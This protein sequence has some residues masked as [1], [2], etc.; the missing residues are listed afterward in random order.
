MIAHD[1][2]PATTVDGTARF[3]IV[4][5]HGMMEHGGRYHDFARHLA[6]HG[7]NVITFDLRGHGQHLKAGQLGDFGDPIDGGAAQIFTDME[8]LFASF[9]NNLPNILFGHSMG[10]TVALRY[11][12]THSGLR[13]IILSAIPTNPPWLLSTGYRLAKLEARL[14]PTKPSVFMTT[15]KQ[16]N[17][18]FKPN[19]TEFDWL[20]LD[21]GNIAHYIDDPMCG[22]PIAP[23]YYVEMFDFMRHVFRTQELA[24]I[25]KNTAILMVWGAD[26]PVTQMGKGPRA[27]LPRLQKLGLATAQIEYP[28][29]R[30]EILNEANRAQVFDDIVRLIQA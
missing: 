9:D 30:H 1:R 3:N 16:F 17:R 28:Q 29:L 23:R 2:F 10:S 26:D 12:Q 8:Q 22:Q 13:Q 19:R 24:K 18:E 5:V 14:R 7:G 21:E 11:A 20:S 27:L 15:F 4:L 6:Q 25:D